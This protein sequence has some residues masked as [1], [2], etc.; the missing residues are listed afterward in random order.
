MLHLD[1][2]L[3]PNFIPD[4]PGPYIAPSNAYLSTNADSMDIESMASSP[5]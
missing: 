1:S 2:N 3:T 4:L 5:R